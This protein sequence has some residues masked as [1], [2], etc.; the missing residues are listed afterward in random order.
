VRIKATW[1]DN[2]T[3]FSEGSIVQITAG[4][5]AY[6]SLAPSNIAEP[7]DD[8]MCAGITAFVLDE[9]SNP[10]I[11]D[12]PIQFGAIPDSI[13]TII[14]D[15]S[16]TMAWF[17]FTCEHV[18]D[19][20][21]ITA[22]FGDLADTSGP[23][24]L[25]IWNGQIEA[26]A[27]PDTIFPDAPGICDTSQI[28]AQ[29]TDGLGCLVANGGI[30]FVSRACGDI[31]G[32]IIDTTDINGYAHTLFQICYEQ[33]PDDPTGCIARIAAKLRGYPDVED[34]VEIYCRRGRQE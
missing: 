26:W 23:I 27:D 30:I 33:I 8:Y 31:V 24:I 9:Y 13:F 6:I 14:E 7:H 34:E 3:V 2:E 28:T 11:P 1:I 22:S 32:Q 17:C 20:V 21:R 10:V 15:T 5:P 16:F 19:T 18:F 29:L 25:P 12:S 4:P